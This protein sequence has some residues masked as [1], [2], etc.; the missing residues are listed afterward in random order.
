MALRFFKQRD[1]DEMDASN[2]PDSFVSYFE[3]LSQERKEEIISSRP[4]LAAGLGYS[5]INAEKNA[6][7]EEK[8]APEEVIQIPDEEKFVEVNNDPED[9]EEDIFSQIRV[10]RYENE[11]LDQFFVDG[12]RP[13]EVLTIPDKTEK[14]IIHRCKFEKKSIKYKS[15]NGSTYGL[16]LNLCRECKRVFQD[17]SHVEHV[18]QALMDRHIPHTFYDVGLTNLYL[19]SQQSAYELGDGEKVYIPDVWIEE[20]PTCPIHEES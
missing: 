1:I 18:H 10:N 9:V 20:N 7:I 11:D 5:I 2:I 4:D 16:V 3:S 13:L 19:R 14:C 8:V 17:E 15:T 12:A 6:V